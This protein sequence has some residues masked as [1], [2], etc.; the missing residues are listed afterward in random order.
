M[1]LFIVQ[2]ITILPECEAAI[3]AELCEGSRHAGH[4]LNKNYHLTNN[5]LCHCTVH[6]SELKMAIIVCYK[7]TPV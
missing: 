7:M 3:E 2:P 6:R 5:K 1:I 4:Q